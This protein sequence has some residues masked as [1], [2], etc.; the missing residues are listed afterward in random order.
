[1]I[2]IYTISCPITGHVKYVGRTHYPENR[3]RSH[4]I[5][6]TLAKGHNRMLY[7]WI[8]EVLEAGFNPIFNVIDSIDSSLGG[9]AVSNMEQFYI[10]HYWK[11]RPLFNIDSIRPA[12]H[13]GIDYKLLRDTCKLKKLKY[14]VVASGIGVKTYMVTGYLSG[15]MARLTLAKALEL[16]DFIMNY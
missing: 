10:V 15:C 9:Y 6:S 1:M 16:K 2:Y 13:A 12:S 8:L 7:G 3:F 14:K 4:V 11:I 5:P